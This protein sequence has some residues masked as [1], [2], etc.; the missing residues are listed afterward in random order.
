MDTSIID[1]WLLNNGFVFGENHIKK[2]SDKNIKII[3]DLVHLYVTDNLYNFNNYVNNLS[4]NETNSYV[5]LMIGN[6]YLIKKLYVLSLEYYI[7]S[8]LQQNELAKQNIEKYIHIFL[9]YMLK[10]PLEIYKQF[11]SKYVL[12]VLDNKK[13]Y[14]IATLYLIFE[15][16]SCKDIIDLFNSH[17]EKILLFEPILYII[18]KQNKYKGLKLLIT[19]EL[20]TNRIEMF[21]KINKII[22]DEKMY[23][24]EREIFRLFVDNECLYNAILNNKIVNS[25]LKMTFDENKELKRDLDE[26]EIDHNKLLLNNNKLKKILE[27]NN[28]YWK[29]YIHRNCYYDNENNI[30]LKHFDNFTI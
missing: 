25:D 28:I 19:D 10:N 5:N 7:K 15:Q 27:D 20:C 30:E 6:I 8:Y 24:L 21:A 17:L 18:I 3:Y 16:L 1:K 13:Q 4:I 26:L 2:I 11:Y 22:L 14:Q 29:D 23:L 9:K 12:H